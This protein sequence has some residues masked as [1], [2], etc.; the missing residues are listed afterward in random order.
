MATVF[1]LSESEFVILQS[2]RHLT[3]TKRQARSDAKTFAQ[4]NEPVNFRFKKRSELK[5]KVIERTDK[6][7]PNEILEITVKLKLT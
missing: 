7:L 2:G 5:G 1:D 4:L 3:I 6:E